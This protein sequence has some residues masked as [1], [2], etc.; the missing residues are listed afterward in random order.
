M[1]S[2]YAMVQA[3]TPHRELAEDGADRERVITLAATRL[4][5]LRTSPLRQQQARHLRF[6]YDLLQVFQYHFTLGQ[7]Q[8]QRLRLHI[9]SLDRG[10]LACLFAAV[11]AD[12]NDLN[13]ADHS[14]ASRSWAN[15][16]NW[17]LSSRRSNLPGWKSWKAFTR[18]T[19]SPNSSRSPIAWRSPSESRNRRRASAMMFSSSMGRW[20][21]CQSNRLR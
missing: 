6:D 7:G 11:F 1:R 16:R 20:L 18:S 21:L 13:L 3:R 15:A 5:A 8:A 2:A 9:G 12:G 17:R 4:A 10:D 14:R 19:A